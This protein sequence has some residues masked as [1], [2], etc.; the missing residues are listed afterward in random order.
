M[1]WVG[2]LRHVVGSV[3]RARVRRQLREFQHATQ[4]CQSVQQTVL[5]NLLALNADSEFGQRHRLSAIQTPADLQKQFPLTN[6]DFYRSDIDQVREGKFNALLGSGNPLLMFSLSSGTTSATKY[7]PITQRFLDDY[8]RGWQVWGIRMLDNYPQVSQ[9]RILQLSSNDDQFRTPGGTRCGSITGLVASLQKRIV[10]SMYTVPGVLSKIE[11]STTR[12][13]TALRIALADPEVALVMTANPST[14]IHLAQRADREAES[15]IRDISDGT[16]TVSA[17]VPLVVR[18]AIRRKIQARNPRRAAELERLKSSRDRLDPQDYWPNLA[19]IAVWTGG[20]AAAYLPKLREYY[21]D[22]P[23]LDP[24]LSASEGR[25]TTPLQDNRP[26]GVL[27]VTSHFF[28]F[29]P[30]AEY[31]SPSPSVLLAHELQIGESY[32]ILLTTSSGF[33]RYDICDVVRCTGYYHTTPTLEFLHKGAHISN[34]TGEK[35]AESQAV[36]A[37]REAADEAGLVLEQFTL[38][39]AWGDPPGYELLT[40]TE[41]STTANLADAIDRKLKTLNSEYADKR[42]SGRLQPL[43]CVALSPGTWQRFAIQR[44]CGEG[45]SVEQYKHPFL[46]PEIGFGERIQKEFGSS[47]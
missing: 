1:S 38:A 9:G 13:Y 30:E 43:R 34:L 12:H 19:L 25:M 20:S 27:D 11:D 45:G 33:Y 4:N 35:I 5:H 44:Q 41:L 40:E 29:I 23:I 21:G 28:E 37:V 22:G 8:R 2:K 24:G 47:T 14:L 15:L 6:Y 39:P 32:Y 26:D 10:Q 36:R 31:G 42:A 7:I 46:S 16:L 3:P 18:S 17:D